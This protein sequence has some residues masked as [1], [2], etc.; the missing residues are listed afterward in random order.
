MPSSN[1]FP[2]KSDGTF[3]KIREQCTLIFVPKGFEN[4]AEFEEVV[5]SYGEKLYP[6][7]Q[8]PFRYRHGFSEARQQYGEAPFKPNHW[9]LITDVLEGSRNKSWQQQAALVDGLAKETLGNW[10][11]PEDYHE[12]FVAIVLTEIGTGK[13]LCQVG[14]EQN[15]CLPSYVRIKQMTQGLRVIVGG[16]PPIGVL[17][18]S[19]Y[20]ADKHE[21]IGVMARW[22]F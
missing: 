6:K 12:L 10:Q 2:K 8:N 15:G 17:V 19:H 14:D 3:Y 13:R 5:K 20:D 7:D 16:S 4:E 9:I 11:V 21:G 1:L 22:K 18:S